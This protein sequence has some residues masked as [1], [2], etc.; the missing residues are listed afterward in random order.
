[1]LYVD[2]S[3]RNFAGM[4]YVFQGC[5]RLGI[6]CA[7]VF[8][9]ATLKRPEKV[10][11]FCGFR[12]PFDESLIV[13]PMRNNL[14]I[15][16]KCHPEGSSEQTSVKAMFKSACEFIDRVAPDQ[17]VLI[18]VLY[19]GELEK[20]QRIFKAKYPRRPIVLYSR[21]DRPDLSVLAEDAVIIS[22]S[23]LQTGANPPPIKLVVHW[24]HAFSVEALLQGAGRA[25][26]S[27]EQGHAV[28][29]SSPHA[30]QEVLRIFKNAQG[31]LDV[32]DLIQ[33]GTDLQRSLAEYFDPTVIMS[34]S[35]AARQADR[36]PQS[37]S[38]DATNTDMIV[39]QRA[40]QVF[41]E[42]YSAADCM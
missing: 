35:G 23:V 42:S 32:R 37:F 9:T 12:F 1:M 6:W 36:S 34:H 41:S 26:R 13:S 30:I 20:L 24:G 38:R 28:L 4:K 33:K 2:D 31:L 27:G 18:F 15:T 25:G 29:L 40:L 19:K 39:L 21:E 22:T 10:L 16:L 11:E 5:T 3:W 14:S 8:M 7:V 17:R